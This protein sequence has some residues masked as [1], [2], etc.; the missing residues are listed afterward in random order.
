MKATKVLYRGVCVCVCVCV[1]VLCSAHL[2]DMC[3][4]TLR[5]YL[6]MHSVTTGLY[7]I[8]CNTLL[9]FTAMI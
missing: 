6:S 1:C 4:M 7:K 3:N 2:H 5:V 9:I 8:L